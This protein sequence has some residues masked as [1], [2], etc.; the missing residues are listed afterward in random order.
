[1]SG[2]KSGVKDALRGL[3]TSP[4]E[5]LKKLRDAIDLLIRAY[6]KSPAEMARLQA[7][8]KKLSEDGGIL[9]QASLPKPQESAEDSP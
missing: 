5:T 8:A 3:S 2:D 9:G 1:M 4:I 7:M 6:E